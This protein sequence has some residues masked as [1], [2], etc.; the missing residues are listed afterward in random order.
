MFQSGDSYMRV[1]SVEKQ[2][3]ANHNGN[4]A[5]AS[6]KAGLLK[7]FSS[8]IDQ[9]AR[10]AKPAQQEL[11]VEAITTK[12]SDKPMDKEEPVQSSASLPKEPP[13][14][15]DDHKQDEALLEEPVKQDFHSDKNQEQEL[16]EASSAD[17]QAESPVAKAEGDASAAASQQTAAEGE[18]AV[19]VVLSAAA[20]EE[21]VVTAAPVKA[22]IQSPSD[23]STQIVGSVPSVKEIVS[24]PT[25]LK[26]NIPN[27]PSHQPTTQQ[28]ASTDV[29]LQVPPA[30]VSAAKLIPANGSTVPI[31]AE[32]SAEIQKMLDFAMPTQG[33]VTPQL[34]KL[35]QSLLS[36]MRGEIANPLAGMSG[37][38]GGA[39]AAHAVLPGPIT[40]HLLA[41]GESSAVKEKQLRTQEQKPM[42]P[43]DSA[44]T[45]KRVQEALEEAAKSRD[46]KQISLRLDP[47]NLGKVNVDVSLRDGTLHARLHAEQPQVVHLLRE[48]AHELQKM[49]R[50]LGLQVD[51]VS[52]AVSNEEGSFS[53][54]K[55][56]FSKS[57]NGRQ[58]DGRGANG[59]SNSDSLEQLAT[60]QGSSE[61]VDS[62]VA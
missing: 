20:P 36:Q 61:P 43:S 59:A 3:K 34:D 33:A 55:R 28:Q 19:P 12:P 13:A 5:E 29:Q 49:L 25:P 44:R 53:S 32:L 37:S 51:Q 38:A 39:A 56:E 57:F 31:Q 42:S 2:G 15:T 40:A 45:L 41:V 21:P 1:E 60:V 7:E 26:P 18:T 4:L 11:P 50:D 8:L 35:V 54:L 52:V 22:E 58:Q 23:V 48:K 24:A 47:P 6:A 27:S 30:Q 9:I 10:Q 46:G 14:A 17:V 62:W 16:A